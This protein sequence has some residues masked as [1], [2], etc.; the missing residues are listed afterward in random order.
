MWQRRP[1]NAE[2]ESPILALSADATAADLSRAMDAETLFTVQ[3]EIVGRMRG[4]MGSDAM[5]PSDD[6]TQALHEKL[7]AL[8]RA[9]KD[10]KDLRDRLAAQLAH[11]HAHT[12]TQLQQLLQTYMHSRKTL[13][14]ITPMLQ[15]LK[16]S[17]Q[18][19]TDE[20]QSLC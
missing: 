19:I 20:Q 15:Q 7:M 5:H 14:T 4:A 12:D 10:A 3:M 13:E 18:K 17:L 16:E 9:E 11:L 1:T 6:E 8:V 2:S